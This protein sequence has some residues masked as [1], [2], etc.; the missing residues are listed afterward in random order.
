MKLLIADDE[1]TIRLG[2]MSLQ[3]ESIGV[4]EVVAAA[5]G[6]EAKEILTKGDVDIMVSDIKMPGLTGLELAQYIREYSLDTKVILLTGFSD[7]E[8]A[9]EAIHNQVCDYI[10]KPLRPKDILNTVARV[11][12]ILEQKRHQ[13][14]ILR[15]YEAR[16]GSS[17]IIVQLQNCF[18]HVN[19]QMTEILIFMG[20]EYATD[21]SL[22]TLA[23][24]WH[25]SSA[26]LSRMFRKETGFSFSDILT[27]IRLMDAVQM[28]V[29][30]KEKIGTICDKTGFKEQ[31][32]F[33]QVFKKVIGSTP[34]DYKKLGKSL[35]LKTI[36]DMMEQKNR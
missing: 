31:R 27:S 28:L 14:Q 26:Y 6:L 29:D 20:K 21:I 18:P 34:G 25:F 22:N 33:S 12:A 15:Q 19:Q 32:Y 13:E 9:Q 16:E 17:D 23:E 2:L 4:T 8:Y 35:K 7:F 30:S 11:I 3:W 10:L 24:K 5:H 36:L 1:M